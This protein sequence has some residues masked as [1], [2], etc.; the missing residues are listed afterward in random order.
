MLLEVLSALTCALLQ[1]C[2]GAGGSCVTTLDGY[3]V[4]SVVCVILGFAWWFFLGPKF[5]KLQDEGQ[6]SWKCKRSN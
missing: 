4:E 5:K 2:T 1:L 3:Y 6:S